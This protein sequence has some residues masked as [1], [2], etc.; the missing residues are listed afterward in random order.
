VYGENI[1]GE[2]DDDIQ[3]GLGLSPVEHVDEIRNA[4]L[5]LAADVRFTAH[6]LERGSPFHSLGLTDER[7]AHA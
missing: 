3:N 1:L 2:I 6:G 4:V 7:P 5:E